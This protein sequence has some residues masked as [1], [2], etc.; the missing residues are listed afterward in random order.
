MSFKNI[1]LIVCL[2]SCVISV[3]SIPN[4]KRT[5]NAEPSIIEEEKNLASNEDIL[6]DTTTI[7]SETIKTQ[8][9]EIDSEI[10]RDESL[11][12]TTNAEELEIST[13]SSQLNLKT[14]LSSIDISLIQKQ[15]IEHFRKQLTANAIRAIF[16]VLNELKR[17]QNVKS[18]EQQNA[19]ESRLIESRVQHEPCDCKCDNES[20]DR[21]DSI[22]EDEAEI[23]IVDKTRRN[24]DKFLPNEKNHSQIKKK[25]KQVENKVVKESPRCKSCSIKGI[26]EMLYRY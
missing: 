22:E 11:I 2:L 13:Q 25:S 7:E 15:L 26:E 20:N 1:Y 9:N 6:D 21:K 18:F 5:N 3:I 17:R 8:E 10:L 23:I 12:K 24:K 4:I 16:L 19:E 14:Q